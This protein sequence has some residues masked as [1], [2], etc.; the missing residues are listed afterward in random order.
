MDDVQGDVLPSPAET[1][2]LPCLADADSFE[3]GEVAVPEYGSWEVLLLAGYIYGSHVQHSCT[4]ACVCSEENIEDDISEDF[5]LAMQ[6]LMETNMAASRSVEPDPS[7]ERHPEVVDDYIR[8]FLIKMG[9]H[10]TLDLFE[11]EWCGSIQCPAMRT[12]E[13]HDRECTRHS[14]M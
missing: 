5:D 1:D 13:V 6:K 11:T 9:M 4:A 7:I 12:C 10:K 8:N 2:L 3:Y 14:E